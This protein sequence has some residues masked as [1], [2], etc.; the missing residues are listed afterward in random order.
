MVIVGREKVGAAEAFA[1]RV[2][3]PVPS[4]QIVLSP[5]TVL[6]NK[7]LSWFGMDTSTLCLCL[8]PRL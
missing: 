6:Y 2:T 8:P 4:R 7:K 5:V 3:R 1:I